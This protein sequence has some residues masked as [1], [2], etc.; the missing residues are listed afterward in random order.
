MEGEDD[1]NF[2]RPFLA[3]NVYVYESYAGK[4]GVEFIVGE[5][6][7]T[8]LRVIG[9]RD[10]DYQI[11]PISDKI[12]YYDYGCMEMMIFKNDDIFRETPHNP[13]KISGA[14]RRHLKGCG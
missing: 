11:M 6:F 5:Y 8:N 3:D 4:S 9:I 14:N 7:A 2:L 12:F 13:I 10:R 1:I